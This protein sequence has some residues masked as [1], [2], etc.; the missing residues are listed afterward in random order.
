MK[1]ET[2]NK[3]RLGIFISVGLIILIAG[4]Y[5]IGSKQQLFS[6]TFRISG[7]FKDINGLQIGNNVRLSG[8]N[9]GVIGNIEI[10]ADTAVRVD[11]VIE[12]KVRKFIKKDSQA[13]I[14]SDGLMGSKMLTI[15]PGTSGKKVIQDGDFIETTAPV[16]IDNILLNL[17]IASINAID[18]TDDLSAIMLNIRSGKGAIGKI[19]MDSTFAKTVDDAM[20]NV[21]EGA[22]GFKQNM[23]AASHNF[24]LRGF[25][26]KKEREK[27]KAMGNRQ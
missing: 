26:K 1:K 6:N 2:G 10:I 15:I 13:N 14:G 3:M 20:V 7:I 27:K 22:G 18:I 16:S 8:I 12:E 24:L 9:V 17:E 11:M 25:L 23:D 21:K 19:F 5:L 4:I